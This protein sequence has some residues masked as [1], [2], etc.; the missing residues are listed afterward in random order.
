M[1]KK[2]RDPKSWLILA[3]INVLVIGYPVNMYLQAGDDKSQLL[4]AVVLVGV[5]FLLAVGDLVTAV[6]SLAG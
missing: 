3:L 1:Q 4:A 6:I 2:K 5:G